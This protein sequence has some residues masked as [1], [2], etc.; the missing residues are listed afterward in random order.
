MQALGWRR[1]GD[2]SLCVSPQTAPGSSSSSALSLQ[3]GSSS[4]LG[5]VSPGVLLSIPVRWHLAACWPSSPYGQDPRLCPWSTV[6]PLPQTAHPVKPSP[7][8][9]EGGAQGLQGEQ[10][11]GLGSHGAFQEGGL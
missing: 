4:P 10:E 9:Q 6:Q 8:D 2:Q 5:L 1:E 3:S 11:R 7:S